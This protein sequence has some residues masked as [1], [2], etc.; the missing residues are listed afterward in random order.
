MRHGKK[1]GIEGAFLHELTR[2]VVERMAAAY[3]ELLDAGARRWPRVVAVGGGALRLDAEAGLGG[4]RARSPRRP[5]RRGALPGA[6]AFR[7]YDTYGLPLDFTEELAQ[8]RGLTVDREGFE[9]ELEAQQERARQASKMGAVT[10]DPV[11]M[12]LLEKG[13]TEF[14]GY[15]GLLVEE[16]HGPGR[17]RGRRSSPRASTRARRARSSSTARRSTARRAARSATTGVIAAEGSAARGRRLPRCPCPAST[18]TT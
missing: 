6:D 12:G 15:D 7:L 2:A 11:Y 18:S 13:K 4:V 3:P 17:A 8:D 10:G 9:R 14:L 5:A 16:A 1:L